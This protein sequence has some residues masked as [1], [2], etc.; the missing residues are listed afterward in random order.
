MQ[1]KNTN[2]GKKK[3][4]KKKE[5]HSSKYSQR[6]IPARGEPIHP[7]KTLLKR[8]RKKTNRINDNQRVPEKLKRHQVHLIEASF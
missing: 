2:R 8:K 7:R 5:S 6:I 3:Q 1:P 4:E